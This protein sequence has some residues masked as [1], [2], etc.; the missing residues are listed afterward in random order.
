MSRANSREVSLLSLSTHNHEFPK[1]H[2][3]EMVVSASL[4]HLSFPIS[5]FLGHSKITMY[6]L[7][8]SYPKD[9]SSAATV[10]FLFSGSLQVRQH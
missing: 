9:S 3:S 10:F 8:P 6:T 7:N 5:S 4:F 2:F 1:D